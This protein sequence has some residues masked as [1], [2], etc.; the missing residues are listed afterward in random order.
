M[1]PTKTTVCSEASER[2]NTLKLRTGLTPNILCRFGLCL[3]LREAEVPDPLAYASKGLEFNQSTLTGEYNS[4]FE[5]LVR[6]RC[7][8]DGIETEEA[9]AEQFRAHLNRG[10]LLLFQN[11]RDIFDLCRLIPKSAA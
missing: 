1:I 9:M 7:I 8:A 6:E 2:L 5:A 3:S 11:C 4:L 10:V